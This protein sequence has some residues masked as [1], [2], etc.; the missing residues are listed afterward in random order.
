MFTVYIAA[1]WKHQ[2]AVDL[3]T[4][5]PR[6][7][8]GVQVL[9]FVENNFSIGTAETHSMSFE[10]WVRSKYGA[11]AFAFDT[12]GAM[13]SDLVVY[14]A[15]SGKDAAAECGMAYGAGVPLVMLYAKG[16]D[17]G[18]NRHMFKHVFNSINELVPFVEL[19]RDG[20]L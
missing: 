20:R 6:S 18:N 11:A 7:L 8:G 13:K 5:L 2:H 12:R 10:E 1:S 4:K 17:F 15:P 14:L 3:L 9:S 16:E 19:A